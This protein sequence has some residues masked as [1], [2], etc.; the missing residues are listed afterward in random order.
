MNNLSNPMPCLRSKYSASTNASPYTM[1]EA[2]NTVP[3]VVPSPKNTNDLAF[4]SSSTPIRESTAI[5]N[6]NNLNFS[7]K[8]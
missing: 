2:V 1:T 3:D 8:A 4:Q 5:S 6:Q 7:L